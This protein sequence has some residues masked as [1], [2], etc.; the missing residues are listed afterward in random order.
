M[1]RIPQNLHER[2]L[3]YLM[4][5]WQWMP[6]FWI[7]DSLLVIYDTWGNVIKQDL[8]KIDHVLDIRATRLVPTTAICGTPSCAIASKL[9]QLLLLTPLVYISTVYLHDEGGLHIRR[10]YVCSV[11]R[12]R[13][14]VNNVNLTRT[15]QRWIK[16]NEI[17]FFSLTRWSVPSIELMAEFE[18]TEEEMNVFSD[19]WVLKQD[20]FGVGGS[21]LV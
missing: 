7:L 3:A 6:S 14:H 15:H 11:L 12:R 8:Q 19:W 5:E 10:P 20:R 2:A 18:Y 17:A 4:L 9:P 1:P 21:V 13:D 16:N